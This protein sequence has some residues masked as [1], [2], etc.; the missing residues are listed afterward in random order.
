MLRL[1]TNV[2]PKTRNTDDPEI[3]IKKCTVKV[4]FATPILKTERS[5]G[6]IK[7]GLGGA[8]PQKNN[9]FLVKR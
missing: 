6:C 4:R 3:L 1:Y 8:A 5:L 7:G 9:V 2:N